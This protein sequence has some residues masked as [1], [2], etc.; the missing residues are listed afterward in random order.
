MSCPWLQ[1]IVV[2]HCRCGPLEGKV[3]VVASWEHG[4]RN[5]GLL[6]DSSLA[7]KDGPVAVV[8]PI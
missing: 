8:N 6:F 2:W 5:S 7:L 4:G 1:Y 3:D